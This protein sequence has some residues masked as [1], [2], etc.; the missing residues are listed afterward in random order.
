MSEQRAS[1]SPIDDVR[2]R[3]RRDRSKSDVTRLPRGLVC[4]VSAFSRRPGSF[5]ATAVSRVVAS[6]DRVTQW[7]RACALDRQHSSL[8]L[9]E[10]HELGQLRLR[11]RGELDMATAPN[12][13]QRLSE[14]RRS[15]QAVVLDLDEVRFIDMSGLRVVL[16]AAR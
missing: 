16:N 1:R 6:S 11:V 3:W 15:H 4:D 7:K 5:T 2:V 10:T 8:D 12:L 9:V 13:A 14:L